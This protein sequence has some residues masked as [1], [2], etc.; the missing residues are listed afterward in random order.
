MTHG[1]AIMII[2]R[3]TDT[4]AKRLEALNLLVNDAHEY[5]LKSFHKI[6]LWET[7]KFLLNLVNETR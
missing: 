3:R 4:V 7:V 1:D 5:D 6:D 2:K